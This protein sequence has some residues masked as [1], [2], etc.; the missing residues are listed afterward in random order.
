MCFFSTFEIFEDNPLRPPL[1]VCPAA[2]VTSVTITITS[3]SILNAIAL[4]GSVLD[5]C[6]LR[7]NLSWGFNQIRLNIIFIAIRSNLRMQSSLAQCTVWSTIQ[8][9]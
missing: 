6:S 8:S 1:R 2:I 4:T 7:E 5:E 9:V 3:A